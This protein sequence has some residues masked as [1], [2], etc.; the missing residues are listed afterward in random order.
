MGHTK[1]THGHHMDRTPPPRCEQCDTQLTI[2]HIMFDCPQHQ[3]ERDRNRINVSSLK[4]DEKSNTRV[5]DY[6]KN[7]GVYDLIHWTTTTKREMQ[8]IKATIKQKNKITLPLFLQF[9]SLICHFHTFA[10]RIFSKRMRVGFTVKYTSNFFKKK[11]NFGA[12]KNTLRTLILFKTRSMIFLNNAFYFTQHKNHQK[13]PQN[14]Q[15]TLKK[16]LKTA[17]ISD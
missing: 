15:K 2:I 9:S 17:I 13:L 16:L 5:I 10:C 14:H 1:L 12:N 8:K 7:L 3:I 6:L 11:N 4:N